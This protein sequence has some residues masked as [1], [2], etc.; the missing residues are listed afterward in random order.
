MTRSEMNHDGLVFRTG[1]YDSF[2]RFLSAEGY[3]GNKNTSSHVPHFLKSYAVTYLHVSANH[4]EEAIVSF[5]A[6]SAENTP[7]QVN[8][9]VLKL[10]EKI[11]KSYGFHCLPQ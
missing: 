11:M 8:A 7:S 10:S 9:V 1:P 6:R 3:S 4:T 5:K 2:S